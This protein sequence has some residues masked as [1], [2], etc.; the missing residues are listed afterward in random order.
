MGIH[1][2]VDGGK[3]IEKHPIFN[4][5]LIFPIIHPR[6]IQYH[7]NIFCDWIA[8]YFHE[9]RINGKIKSTFI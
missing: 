3:L 2:P 8:I 5:E 7:I 9:K 6:Q 4:M 1:S